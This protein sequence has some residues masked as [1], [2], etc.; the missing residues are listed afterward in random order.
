MAIPRRANSIP[1]SLLAF[2]VRPVI[3]YDPRT[4]RFSRASPRQTW[5][6]ERSCFADYDS[7]LPVER[8]RNLLVLR[9]ARF[10]PSA[11]RLPHANRTVPNVGFTPLGAT[12]NAGAVKKLKAT[13]SQAEHPTKPISRSPKSIAFGQS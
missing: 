12:L 1:T 6:R 11:G 5:P 3:L 4:K 9:P 2:R 13:R 10:H 7:G 8:N